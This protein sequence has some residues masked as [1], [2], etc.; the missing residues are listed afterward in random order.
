MRFLPLKVP[1][2]KWVEFIETV[3]S[4]HIT[5]AIHRLGTGKTWLR[6]LS[7]GPVPNMENQFQRRK[8]FA[9]FHPRSSEQNKPLILCADLLKRHWATLVQ[10]AF[11]NTVN[12]KPSSSSLKTNSTSIRR[13]PDVR[14]CDSGKKHLK[15]FLSRERAQGTITGK[16]KM[17]MPFCKVKGF[18]TRQ[19]PTHKLR[20]IEQRQSTKSKCCWNCKSNKDCLVSKFKA[21]SRSALQNEQKWFIPEPLYFG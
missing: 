9:L 8:K 6:T 12:R 19:I 5:R 20:T 4:K 11:I 7:D 14:T 3:K 1:R 2:E 16:G 21:F 15:T 18:W 13:S 17:Q 10:A